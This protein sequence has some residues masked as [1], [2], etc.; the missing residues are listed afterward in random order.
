MPTATART[1]RLTLTAVLAA[2]MLAACA[3][4]QQTAAEH[5][6][7]C[8][9]IKPGALTSVNKMCV[10]VNSHPVNPQMKTVDW[11]GQEVGF[12]CA[13]CVPR[14]EKMSDAQKDAALAQ[15]IAKSAN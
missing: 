13:G 2:T 11:K 14:W 4:R 7:E 15:A 3:A 9:E 12:C 6:A 1:A 8:L 10:V 5:E